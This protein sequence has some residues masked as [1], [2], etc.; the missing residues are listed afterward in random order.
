MFRSTAARRGPTRTWRRRSSITSRPRTTSR[1]ACA[2]RSRT[3]PA[4]AGRAAGRAGST[5]R[6]GTTWPASRAT[7]RP[8]PTTP[9]SPTVATTRR[10][11][12][13]WTT[14]PTPSGSSVRGPTAPT[15]T[16]RRRGSTASS[17]PRGCGK[18]WT[19]VTPK[20]LGDFTRV[21]IIEAS[22]YAPGTAYVAANRY[23]L[24]DMAPY[25][26]KTTDY[27]HT[28]SK[29]VKGLPATEFVRV[30]RE[31][32]VRRGLLFAGTERGVWVSFDDGASWHV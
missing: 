8:G 14:R 3:P 22:H 23:Q 21:S 11:W 32:P 31:D 15:V 27:G 29:I 28:W 6:S 19:D 13:G 18:K 24:E 10:S 30:V 7:F 16:R 9:T 1:I 2:A 17:G 26:W 25:I 12:A 20:G 4:G 5:G